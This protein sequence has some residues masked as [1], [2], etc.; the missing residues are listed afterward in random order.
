[1][2][3]DFHYDVV[4]VLARY[5]DFPRDEAAII[6]YSSQYVD[7]A[8][9]GGFIKFSN[10]KPF[11][12]MRTAHGMLSM[13][14]LDEMAN[15]RAWMP[16]HFLPGND[17]GDATGSEYEYVSRLI[18]RQNSQIAQDMVAECIKAK[19][20]VNGLHRLG[21]TL[22]VYADTWAHQGFAGIF[23]DINKI[24]QLYDEDK[25][26]GIFERLRA[27]LEDMS[28][29]FTSRLLDR[30]PLGHGAAMHCPDQPFLAWSYCD[31]F[32]KP[33][34]RIDNIVRFMDAVENV[35]AVLKKYQASTPTLDAPPL[36]TE[37]RNKI[38]GLLVEFDN[39]NGDFRHVEWQT[40]MMRDHFG[41]KEEAYPYVKGYWKKSALNR[42]DITNKYEEIF[43]FNN[44]FLD[45]NWK[46]YHEAALTHWDIVMQLL[47]KHNVI[48]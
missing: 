44:N 41:F 21:L 11:Y 13:E 17:P 33:T 38:E 19:N 30:L 29:I 39:E 31:Y 46:K 14:N 34:G 32:E 36:P 26:H 20:P 12:H 10:Y 25:G 4:Y 3:I 16:F 28:D 40:K 37:A 18:C 1:M 9:N 23:H 45:S 43:E 5:A 7:D 2:Q 15:N 6:A 42:E 27:K 8:L 48:C 22:H 24:S 47:R 35:W